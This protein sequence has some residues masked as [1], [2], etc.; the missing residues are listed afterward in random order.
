M[1][2]L[3]ALIALLGAQT[4]PESISYRAA[5][6]SFFVSGAG[7]GSVQEIGPSGEAH[8]FLPPGGDGRTEAYGIKV[9]EAHGR[10]WL[11]D[12]KAVFIYRLDSRALEKKITRAE[13]R[14]A[15]DSFLNDLAL[16]GE[17]NAYVTDSRDPS[18]LVISGSGL[19]P[20]LRA[21]PIPFAKGYNLN[22]IVISGDSL[23]SVKT[24]DGSLW[25]IPLD[26][27]KAATE[28]PLSAPV[29]HGDGL[30]LTP[31][32]ALLVMRNYEEKIS[33]VD[34]VTGVVSDLSLPGLSTPTSA[35]WAANGDLVVVNSQFANE[36]P[37][38]PFSLARY[39]WPQ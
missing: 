39:S 35:A 34:L 7:D 24:N 26:E 20:H 18:L 25:R 23:F 12:G 2:M 38:L 5:T 14:A 30:L 29:T 9:D 36:V 3:L 11:V 31:A 6:D 10:L 22:G 17:G 21:L 33:R 19:S 15:T 16:D 1:L 28:V 4:Y 27:A 32:G 8:Y 13:L 37:E